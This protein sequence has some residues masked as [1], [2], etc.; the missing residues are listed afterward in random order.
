MRNTIG[1]DNIIILNTTGNLTMGENVRYLMHKCDIVNNDWSQ[2]IN[3]LYGNVELYSN[4]LI[5]INTKRTESVI[6][7]L[8]ESRDKM[9]TQVFE[10][11]ELL[12]LIEM[13]CIN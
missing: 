3:I 13:L 2:N 4:R 1:V 9:N 7:E 8:C 10:S 6:I 12:C 5:N 11:K